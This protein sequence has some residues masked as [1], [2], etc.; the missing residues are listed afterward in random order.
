MS[1]MKR[2]VRKEIW[3]GWGWTPAKRKEYELRKNDLVEAVREQ[4]AAFNIFV[5]NMGKGPRIL[6][7]LEAAIMNYL[8]RSAPPFCDIPDKGMML[9]PKWVTESPIMVSMSCAAKLY[10][11]PQQLEI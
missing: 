1:A 11:I 3:H 10:G 8:Y 7:R 6:E 2:G 5:A 4:L 9:A